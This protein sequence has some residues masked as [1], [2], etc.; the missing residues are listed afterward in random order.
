MGC[1]AREFPRLLSIRETASTGIM[2]EYSLRALV[3]MG[4]VPGVDVG[5]KYLVNYDALCA[6]LWAQAETGQNGRDNPP[7]YVVSTEERGDAR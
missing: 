6:M 2:P 7:L 5:G 3:K 4:K 1:V